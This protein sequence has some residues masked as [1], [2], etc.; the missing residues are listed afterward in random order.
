[1]THIHV[2]FPSLFFKHFFPFETL[3]SS[4]TAPS[5]SVDAAIEAATR[6]GNARHRRRRRL[7]SGCCSRRRC[8]YSSAPGLRGHVLHGGAREAD[9]R[10]ARA[11][12][13]VGRGRQ[14]AVAEEQKLFLLCLLCFCS[15]FRRLRR[16]GFRHRAPRGVPPGLV[17]PV[18]QA[19]GDAQGRERDRGRGPRR[20]ERER[21]REFFLL[22]SL[23]FPFPRLSSTLDLLSLTLFLSLFALLSRDSF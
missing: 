13:G 2:S 15:G 17:L 21:E 18:R 20:G 14:G 3:S 5:V 7:L 9:G 6:H 16:V 1:M 11:R 12:H 4:S 22:F 19:D 8:E 10:A 23:S